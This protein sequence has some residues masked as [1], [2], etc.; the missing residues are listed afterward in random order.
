MTG[1]PHPPFSHDWGFI[2]A[3]IAGGATAKKTDIAGALRKATPEIDNL[4]NLLHTPDVV[5]LIQMRRVGLI[6]MRGV[7]PE[8]EVLLGRLFDAL[9]A[10]LFVPLSVVPAKVQHHIA[11][12]I[13][14]P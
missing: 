10:L 6:Q 9:E 3:L 14:P 11:D 13:D 8:D 1:K 12:L 5:N 7:A 2:A 4:L